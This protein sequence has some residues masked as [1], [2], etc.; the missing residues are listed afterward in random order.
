MLI[1]TTDFRIT[2]PALLFD[3]GY[4]VFDFAL[5]SG[6][7][8]FLVIDENILKLAPFTDI[9]FEPI[10]PAQFTLS[11]K[12]LFALERMHNIRRP[13]SAFIFHHAFVCSTLLARCLNQIDAFFSLKEPWILRRLADLKRDQGRR[14]P[15][16][17]WRD[18]FTGYLGL[19]A[20]NYE[21]GRTPVIKVTNV[22]NNLMTDVLEYL[23]GHKILYLYS[24]LESFLVSNL[25]KP[26]DTQ[27]KMPGLAIA[28]LT[29]SDFAQRF[30][31]FSNVPK[32]DFL[33]V[34]ALI[35]LVNLYNFQH[36]IVQSEQS[37]VRTLE[38]S[39][40]LA[41]M[42]ANLK[43]L[44]H[45]FGHEASPDEI[46]QMMDPGVTETDAKHQD[47]MYGRRSKQL[48]AAQ[49]LAKHGAEIE[50]TIKWINPL[51]EKLGIL[52]FCSA[53]KLGS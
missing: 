21:T 50:K 53:H 7:T 4:F 52:D 12:E 17:Q 29:D 26:R 1:K 25:K 6:L 16:N 44:S 38:M 32:L 36:S 41:D 5:D 13:Q 24:D 10:A 31:V 47:K 40:F 23:P 20:K 27:E 48:E 2:A 3:P 9:R 46:E 34:C 39:D 43:N 37:N 45:F 15:S 35:W 14:I 8:R 22:A 18:M 42:P 33:Q 11:T 19:L 51:V 49:I 30:P 28:F